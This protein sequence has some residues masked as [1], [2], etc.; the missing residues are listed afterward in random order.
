MHPPTE[1]SNWKDSQMSVQLKPRYTLEEYFELE[2]SSAERWEYFNGEVFCMSGCSPG[3]SLIVGN[4]ITALNNKLRGRDCKVFSADLRIVVP[5]APPYR[6]ADLSV[7]C[8]DP[9]FEKIG[10]VEAL[11]N[12]VVLIEVLSPST[13]AYDRGD[14]F[15]YYKSILSLR[16]YLL[17]AQHRPHIT[18]YV[19][20][21][22]GNW[23]YEEVNDLAANITLPGINCTLAL[24]D[25]YRSVEFE[26][27]TLPPPEQR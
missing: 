15:T 19:R 11:L 12:P 25:V 5:A 23:D 2:R 20:Q 8:A 17:V 18:H 13:E 27:V 3:H 21:S 6:Y 24:S 26:P 7:L 22:T 9:V 1:S 16:E 14:K 10:G 4:S